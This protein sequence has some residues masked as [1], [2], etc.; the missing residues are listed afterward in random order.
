MSILQKPTKKPAKELSELVLNIFTWP[1]GVFSTRKNLLKLN[2]GTKIVRLSYKGPSR[3]GRQLKAADQEEGE[4]KEKKEQEAVEY[5][6]SSSSS[7]RAARDAAAVGL[8]L[9]PARKLGT[10]GE[11]T[12]QSDHNNRIVAVTT[13]KVGGPTM[14]KSTKQSWW[15]RAGA[16]P[17][18]LGHWAGS[19]AAHWPLCVGIS[20]YDPACT[21]WE[22]DNHPIP[23][24]YKGART[25]PKRYMFPG[26]IQVYAMESS[27]SFCPLLLLPHLPFLPGSIPV[28][29]CLVKTQAQER[30]SSPTPSF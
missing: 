22:H 6:C 29:L 8:K 26:T 27:P 16:V 25:V 12:I 14:D 13:T 2:S 20:R 9:E 11:N 18:R 30:A 19:N 24:L 28:S 4:R 17:P 23:I 5:L 21:R 10:R 1:K 3:L 15:G 7:S